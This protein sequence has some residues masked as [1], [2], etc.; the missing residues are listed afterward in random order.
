[1][2]KK[3]C[4]TD[5]NVEEVVEEKII[6]SRFDSMGGRSINGIYHTAED[7]KRI[8]EKE[9][10]IPNPYMSLKEKIDLAEMMFTRKKISEHK[11]FVDPRH[12]T[13]A[14]KYQ[15]YLEQHIFLNMETMIE[16]LKESGMEAAGGEAYVRDIFQGLPIEQDGRY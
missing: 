2:K 3:A 4:K 10:Y 11:Q 5:V 16:K 13:I 9:E 12:K 14:Y 6:K 7:L 1:M 8:G 15:N